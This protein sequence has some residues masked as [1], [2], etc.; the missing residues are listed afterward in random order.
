[1]ILMAMIF[2]WLG[3][4]NKLE[5]YKWLL[6]IGIWM[7]PI[8]FL[9]SMSGWV[10][11]EVGRQ[12]WTID[13]LLATSYSTSNITSTAVL[14]TFWIFLSVLLALVVAEFKIMLNAIKKGPNQ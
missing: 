4:K 1:M 14:L 7:F 11:V 3:M 13:G 10:V 9:A 5:K 12:P 6:K 2:L 8:S